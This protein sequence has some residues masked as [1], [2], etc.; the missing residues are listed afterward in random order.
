[1]FLD[2]DK[3]VPQNCSC[4]EACN[5]TFF[6]QELSYSGISKHSYQILR[7]LK[8]HIE[9]KYKYVTEIKNR[10]SEDLFAGTMSLLYEFND[11]LGDVLFF[12]NDTVRDYPNC[13][14]SWVKEGL[15]AI[16]KLGKTDVNDILLA[17]LTKMENAYMRNFG[18]MAE[19]VLEFYDTAKHYVIQMRALI[20]SGGAAL[21]GDSLTQR[22]A[23]NTQHNLQ[24]LEE[25]L[26]ALSLASISNTSDLNPSIYYKGENCTDDIIAGIASL[27]VELSLLF[28]DIL[29]YSA[30]VDQVDLKFKSDWRANALGSINTLFQKAKDMEICLT[31]FKKAIDDVKGFVETFCRKKITEKRESSISFSYDESYDRI[32]QIHQN[33]TL[34][35]NKYAS[36]TITKEEIFN[37]MTVTKGFDIMDTL[38]EIFDSLILVYI[39]PTEFDMVNVFTDLRSFYI[40]VLHSVVKLNYYYQDIEF[41]IIARQMNI[42]K[43][44]LPNLDSEPIM[45]YSDNVKSV[46]PESLSLYEFA[47][48]YASQTLSYIIGSYISNLR[49]SLSNVKKRMT[50]LTAGI[51][52][53]QKKIENAADEYEK[54]LVIDESFMR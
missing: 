19:A 54:Q 40:A 38:Q 8:Q 4:Q 11:G 16:L 39:E 33:I 51:E 47:D 50:Q 26:V 6:S 17:S 3:N 9:Q 44:P 25:S 2:I 29:D 28:N 35:I 12:L 49:N 15:E 45:S 48:H 46:W 20:E 53:T 41:D 34:F 10:A 36:G 32:Y 14:L 23:T 37:V 43:S 18:N 5:A 24:I 30:F 52:T 27:S 22:L 42:L 7:N 13:V 1:M 21:L 31:E